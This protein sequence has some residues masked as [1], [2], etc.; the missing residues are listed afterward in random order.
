M[1]GMMGSK[2]TVVLLVVV[3]IATALALVV[4]SAHKPAGAA[5]DQRPDLSM[6]RIV[7]VQIKV[8]TDTRGDCDKA[9]QH[10]L[11]FATRIVNVG[12]GTFQV[13]GSN[14][15]ATG[16]MQTVKQRIFDDQGGSRLDATKVGK[17]GS[18][19]QI[20][21]AGD[22][23]NHWHLKNLEHYTLSG[24]NQT[25]AKGGFCFFDNVKWFK[26]DASGNPITPGVPSNPVYTGCANNQPG[27][28]SVTMGLSKGWGDKYGVKSIG[29]YIDITGLSDGSYRLT[30]AAD[31]QDWLYE[32]NE[33][34]NA[35]WVDLSISNNGT[36]VSVTGYGGSN[37]AKV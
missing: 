27:A 2:R 35:T 31:E 18:T 36:Q 14:P 24:S 25:G 11:R 17:D 10:Q 13:E 19:A 30:A 22:G 7:D 8:C 29:Q 3:A 23:H 28:Q 6:A 15:D 21:Y 37:P 4:A 34:N 20:Y 26:K 32:S 1:V 5:T 9:G 12:A 33:V 16:V